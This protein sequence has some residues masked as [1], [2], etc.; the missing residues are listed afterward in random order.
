MITK[1][2]CFAVN[3]MPLLLSNSSVVIKETSQIHEKIEDVTDVK[4]TNKTQKILDNQCQNHY[5]MTLTQ[6]KIQ[7][8]DMICVFCGHKGL[9]QMNKSMP[10]IRR[11]VYYKRCKN[12]NKSTNYRDI[13]LHQTMYNN[14]LQNLIKT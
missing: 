4:Q 7:N 9:V 8:N 11:W 12:C 13:L 2:N 3:S 14:V 6:L 5:N 1:N 10:I